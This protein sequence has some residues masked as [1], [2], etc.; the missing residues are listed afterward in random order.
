MSSAPDHITDEGS[1]H[2]VNRFPKLSTDHFRLRYGVWLSSIG[3]GTYLGES[4]AASSTGY[5]ES[6]KT[7]IRNGCNVIDTAVNY[8][9]MQSERDI[10]TALKQLYEAGEFA[11]DEIL[12]CTKGGYIPYDGEMPSDPL[13]DIQ[14]RFVAK[15]LAKAEEIVGHMHCMAPDFLSS[16]IEL[17]RKNLGTDTI[18]VYYLHNPETQLAYISPSEFVKRLRRAFLRL[19]EEVVHGHILAYGIASWNGLRTDDKAKDYLPLH[20]L[21]N[22]ANEIAGDE[23]HF[24]FLQFPY[25]LG[26]LEALNVRNQ[27]LEHKEEDGSIKR[28]AMPLLAAAYQFGMTS[29]TSAALLQT[30]V[31]TR[32]PNKIRRTFGNFETDAQ[33]AVHF[34]RST[35]GVTTTLVGMA[36]PDHVVE[37]MAVAKVQ[38]LTQDEFFAKLS[39]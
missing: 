18:D 20:M 14:K 16:Q 33:Y 36:T 6:I 30:Q 27:Y 26:M 13:A 3:I 32:V 25:N 21:V 12:I 2:Y 35:P 39:K 15:R 37:N 9:M 4:D 5:V 23:H 29:I 28:T 34:N 38:P 10:S 1:Q 19:E 11:R 24:R 22:I 8:R 31:L 7:A 17:S